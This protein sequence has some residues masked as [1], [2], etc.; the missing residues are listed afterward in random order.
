MKIFSVVKNRRDITITRLE[1]L[2][3]RLVK[4]VSFHLKMDMV[5]II[6]A[7]EQKGLKEKNLRIVP[8]R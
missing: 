3:L 8:T 6:A 7:G 2:N 4:S 1:K 5:C